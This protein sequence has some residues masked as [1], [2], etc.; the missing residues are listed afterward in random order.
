MGTI[1]LAPQEMEAG[2]DDV[3]ASPREEGRIEAIVVRPAEDERQ[4]RQAAQL[5]PEGG[6]EGDR[7]ATESGGLRLPDGRPDPRAQVS[8]M[9]VRILR[10]IA[11][12]E[13]RMELAGDNLIVDLDLSEENMAVGER[14]RAGEALL[15]VTDVPHTGC[16]KFAQRFG[17]DATR[18]INASARADLH[19]R[20]RYARVIEAGKVRVGDL[21]QKVRA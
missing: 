4:L 5:T 8:L 9:N 17:P 1:H 21:V 2:L 16:G 3:L 19:L 6:V 10:L 7:W 13:A 18:F 15:E 14:L 12:Q 20:G 11:G